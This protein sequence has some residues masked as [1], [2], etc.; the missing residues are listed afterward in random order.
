M[1]LEVTW[2]MCLLNRRNSR[3]GFVTQNVATHLLHYVDV[4]Y[5]LCW[6]VDLVMVC[7]KENNSNSVIN[8]ITSRLKSPRCVL[9]GIVQR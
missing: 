3:L 9:I 1:G 4:T 2:D 6:Q 5:N 7:R 8:V